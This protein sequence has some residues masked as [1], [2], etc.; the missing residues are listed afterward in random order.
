VI[1][2]ETGQEAR[3][4]I[5]RKKGEM[6]GDLKGGRRRYP[7]GY[8][9]ESEK[10]LKGGRGKRGQGCVEGT[11]AGRR[12]PTCPLSSGVVGKP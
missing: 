1:S 12:R 11:K 3:V 9:R 6:G 4:M 7:L 2:P 8:Q 10:L 5:H